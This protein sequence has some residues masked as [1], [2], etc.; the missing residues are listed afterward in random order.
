LR[1]PRSRLI[2]TAV[3]GVAFGVNEAVVVVYLRGAVGLLPTAASPEEVLARLPDLFSQAEIVREASTILILVAVSLLAASS[4]LQ[5]WAMFLWMFAFWDIF[6]YV[7]LW[8]I[9]GWPPSFFTSDV[10]FLI[11]TPWVAQV[12]FPV[13]VSLLAAGAVAVARAPPGHAGD[14]E[15]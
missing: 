12:W 15:D 2:Q 13:L 1:L 3:F 7:G 14:R 8:L 9:I 5:R 6:Y 4:L 10:L 11:P